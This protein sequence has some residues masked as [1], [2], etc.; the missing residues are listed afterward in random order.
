MLDAEWKNNLFFCTLTVTLDFIFVSTYFTEFLDCINKGRDKDVLK[1]TGHLCLPQKKL[2]IERKVCNW[3]MTKPHLPSTSTPKRLQSLKVTAILSWSRQGDSGL[4]CHLSSTASAPQEAFTN[5]DAVQTSAML[6]HTPTYLSRRKG[7]YLWK[8]S[9]KYQSGTK[10]V[11]P[12]YTE[13]SQCTWHNKEVN[14][15]HTAKAPR[16]TASELLGKLGSLE[17]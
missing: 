3:L 15:L 7:W 16:N 4:C 5:T 12:K 6:P 1:R 14:W 2:E 8:K 17:H 9:G 10:Q 11:P 13:I